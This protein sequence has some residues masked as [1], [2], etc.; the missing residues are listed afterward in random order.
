LPPCKKTE[1]GDPRLSVIFRLLWLYRMLKFARIVEGYGSKR[2]RKAEA[3]NCSAYAGCRG[4]SLA[5]S[6]RV[7]LQEAKPP[8]ASQD[9][10]PR[11]C[12]KRDRSSLETIRAGGFCKPP[13]VV[14]C[15][16]KKGAGG[17]LDP[18]AD[19][20]RR[21]EFIGDTVPRPGGRSFFRHRTHLRRRRW[22]LHGPCQSLSCFPAQS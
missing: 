21:G 9:P 22:L 5:K 20:D 17:R 15:F 12:L 7:S 10:D 13:A 16:G 14:T 19:P 4:A 3:H 2:I 11:P 18:R 8:K 6:G 1:W